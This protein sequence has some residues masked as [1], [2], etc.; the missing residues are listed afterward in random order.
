MLEKI[1]R[2]KYIHY[3][4]RIENTGSLKELAKKLEI[5]RSTCAEYIRLLRDIGAEIY[6]SHARR[7]YIYGQ[8]K[9][10]VFGSL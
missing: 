1:N 5:S 4:I 7:S 10:F 2:L 3:L 9:E 8:K 6:Y